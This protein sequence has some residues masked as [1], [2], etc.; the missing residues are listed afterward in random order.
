MNPMMRQPNN[1]HIE[2]NIEKVQKLMIQDC[3]LSVRIKS[4]AAD[5]NNSIVE[6]SDRRS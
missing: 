4:K 6:N 2:E 3:W 5:I 1:T